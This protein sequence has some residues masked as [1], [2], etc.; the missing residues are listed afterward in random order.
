ME[1]PARSTGV[2][3]ATDTGGDKN[4]AS[5]CQPKATSCTVIGEVKPNASATVGRSAFVSEPRLPL[6]RCSA[7]LQSLR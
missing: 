4:A 6:N 2:C 7:S 1:D 3:D 5:A